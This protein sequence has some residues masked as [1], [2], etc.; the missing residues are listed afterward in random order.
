MHYDLKRVRESYGLSIPEFAAL[1]GRSP[2]RY[3]VF[4]R[5]GEIPCKH[6]YMLWKQ[7]P[8]FPVPDDFFHYTSFTLNINMRYHRL[9]QVD[10]AEMFGMRQATVSAYFLGNPIPMYELKDKF[11]ENFNP[12]IIP[13]MTYQESVNGEA[14]LTEIKELDCRGNFVAS[15]RKRKTKKAATRCR[16]KKSASKSTGNKTVVT[17]TVGK[18]NQLAKA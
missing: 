14:K 2:S 11:L 7:L 9:K 3:E 12:L 17:L 5:D 8:D 13:C 6:I 10:I 16:K 15:K 1:I 18:K 4:E